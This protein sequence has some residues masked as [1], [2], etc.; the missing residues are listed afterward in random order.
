MGAVAV[1]Q[2][3][4][5]DAKDCDV[6]ARQILEAA[7][8]QL[9]QAA[10]QETISWLEYTSQREGYDSTDKKKESSRVVSGIRLKFARLALRRPA[11]LFPV[12]NHRTRLASPG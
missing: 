6:L 8:D 4:V 1:L 9:S 2:A 10:Q 3:G 5:M 11:Q 7:Y 12:P